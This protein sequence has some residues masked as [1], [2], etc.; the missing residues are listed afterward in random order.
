MS[1]TQPSVAPTE[2]LA[3]NAGSKS[4]STTEPEPLANNNAE[5]S[6]VKVPH[7][8][9][10]APA[11]DFEA[12]AKK[13]KC[14]GDSDAVTS[15]IGILLEELQDYKMKIDFF[16]TLFGY[17]VEQLMAYDE[18][19]IRHNDIMFYGQRRLQGK[20]LQQAMLEESGRE[21]SLEELKG[22]SV[23]LDVL[24]DHYDFAVVLPLKVKMEVDRRL[25]ST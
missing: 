21:P 9:D 8:D 13:L 11:F 15:A 24:E 22:K 16:E 18:H 5:S 25:N 6:T 23:I 3:I 12:A 20:V 10:P 2:S 1:D 17:R 19:L 4:R 7:R 14:D